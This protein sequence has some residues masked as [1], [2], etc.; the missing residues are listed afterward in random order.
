DTDPACVAALRVLAAAGAR[1]L[2]AIDLEIVDDVIPPDCP[3]AAAVSGSPGS[4]PDLVVT[5]LAA[6]LV[7]EAGQV[8]TVEETT[9]NTGKVSAATSLTALYLSPI[10]GL[11]AGAR[12][13]AQ[14]SVPALGA[15]KA[16][17]AKTQVAV[18]PDTKT[19]ALFLVAAADYGDAIGEADEHNNIAVAPIA[20]TGGGLLSD[21]ALDLLAPTR[22]Q[23]GERIT[24]RV[25]VEN[26]SA[27]PS[28]KG[29]LK[30]Y[31]WS[32]SRKASLGS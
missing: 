11:G 6:P 24:V 31:L 10:P 1:P 14:R 22:A 27:E 17:S 18:P 13:L 3:E 25:V 20:I 32:G 16:S 12:E 2:D 7:A 23:P 15:G 9:R 30:F 26:H 4:A 21:L 5:Q 28:E 19:A 8:I 29:R